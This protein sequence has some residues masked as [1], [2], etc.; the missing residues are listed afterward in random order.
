MV[1]WA[2]SDRFGPSAV[3][4]LGGSVSEDYTRLTQS[5]VVLRGVIITTSV[6]STIITQLSPLPAGPGPGPGYTSYWEEKVEEILN[7]SQPSDEY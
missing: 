1:V 7:R 2:L 6:L 3:S 5:Q 4:P